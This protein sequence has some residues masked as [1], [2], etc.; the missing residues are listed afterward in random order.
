MSVK[1]FDVTGQP[2]IGFLLVKKQK[3]S[4]WSEITHFFNGR[5]I[6]IGYFIKRSEKEIIFKASLSDEK[7]MNIKL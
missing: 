4:E 1:N 7:H 3:Q 5:E 2:I 6:C